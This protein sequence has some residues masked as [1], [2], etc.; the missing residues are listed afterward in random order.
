MFSKIE[1]E[2]PDGSKKKVAVA[3]ERMGIGGEVQRSRAKAGAGAS[4][5]R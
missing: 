1:L 5:E 2:V 3:E 4:G